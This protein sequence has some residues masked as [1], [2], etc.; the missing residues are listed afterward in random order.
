MPIT[1][2]AH[3]RLATLLEHKLT[4]DVAMPILFLVLWASG[5]SVVKIGLRYA[6]PLTFLAMRYA[7]VIAILLPIQLALKLPF[8]R[9]AR[10][11]VDLCVIGFLIQFVY[12]G[13]TYLALR[14]GLSVGGL[15][16]IVSMQ[17][18]VV[19][20]VSPLWVKEKVSAKQWMGLALGFV[21][22]AIVI[23]SK[24]IVELTSAKG[25]A[26]AV[27]ALVG[28]TLGVLYEKRTASSVHVI[29]STLIQSCVGLL[30]VVPLA[31]ALE[32]WHVKWVSAMFL[33]LAYLVI[34]NS[35]IAIILLLY[36]IRH[37]QAAKVSALFFLVPP[38]AAIAAKVLVNETMPAV[39]WGGIGVAAIGVLISNR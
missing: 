19:G 3:Q 29:G 27:A 16:L 11:W 36:L 14:A 4:L 5:F 23:I 22:A 7:C 24:S 6:E 15:A 33:S 26:L 1:H 13:G 17:P 9:T 31:N 32:H 34:C 20:I 12:F 35:L 37:R 21:G 8:P 10:H 28:M 18:I 38:C 39:A 2:V 30:F 25:I